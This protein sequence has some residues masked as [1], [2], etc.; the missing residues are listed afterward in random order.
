MT[1][2][3]IIAGPQSSGKTTVL[4]HLRRLHKNW[5]FIDEINPTSITGI[6]NFGAIN[7]TEELEKKIIETDIN[8][9]KSINRNFNTAVIETGIFHCVYASHFFSE[10]IA[11]QY[12]NMYLKAHEGLKP[13]VIFIDT[14]PQVSW[15]RRKGRY[16]KRIREKRIREKKKKEL[17]LKKYRKTIDDLYPHWLRI[18][19]KIPFE[20]IKMMNNHENKSEF[21]ENIDRI[22]SVQK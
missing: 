15:E 18:F 8:K 6:K 17:L 4:K 1:R 14:K 9:I 22:L 12:F 2:L 16:L 11:L 3:I 10:K 20:K 5:E 13:Y 19:K 21:L 7:T